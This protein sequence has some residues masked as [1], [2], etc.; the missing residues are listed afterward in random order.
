MRPEPFVDHAGTLRDSKT[1]RAIGNVS[2]SEDEDDGEDMTLR[3]Y[4][5]TFLSG[6]VLIDLVALA[7]YSFFDSGDVE[8]LGHRRKSSFANVG[9]LVVGF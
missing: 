6:A 8:L 3:E 9:K 5:S 2:G 4:L 1:G 7:G